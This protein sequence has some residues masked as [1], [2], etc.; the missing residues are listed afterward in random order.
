MNATYLHDKEVTYH[1]Y[2]HQWMKKQNQMRR[3]LT[4]QDRFDW[5]IPTTVH[6][7]YQHD[8]DF[9]RCRLRHST[10]S[11]KSGAQRT[12]MPKSKST[13]KRALRYIGG[14]DISF[15]KP[16]A[17]EFDK[18][19]AGLTIF[20]YPSMRRVHEETAI[21][22]LQCPYI[23]GFLAFREVAH[24]VRVIRR[25]Q[26]GKQDIVPDVILVDGNGI[27]HYRRMGLASHLAM[28]V[29]IPCIGVAKRLLAIDNLRPEHLVP[30]WNRCLKDIGAFS[31]IRG[32]NREHV[33]YALRIHRT[34]DVV[35][36]SPGHRIGL[37]SALK[38]VMLS[39]DTQRRY[40]LP[41]PTEFADRITRTEIK[42]YQS[43]HPNRYRSGDGDR[44][45]RPFNGPGGPRPDRRRKSKDSQRRGK[46][47]QSQSVIPRH[48]EKGSAVK[49]RRYR[50]KS[51]GT[52]KSKAKPKMRAAE[53]VKVVKEEK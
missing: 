31:K 24:L 18:A 34:A 15:A 52:A 35:Y 5:E 14:V 38:V 19:S 28:E 49:L 8:S 13:P 30:H 43:E 50:P 22:T 21:V 53:W 46:P 6:I 32:F 45:G 10:E 1:K 2:R 9:G 51:N 41:L 25:V 39:L 37:E 36:V 40:K 17:F 7:Q 27:L 47:A 33:G 4:V 3:H 20:E 29:D 23:A 42:R 16:G 48:D 12:K 44:R 11:T 26:R